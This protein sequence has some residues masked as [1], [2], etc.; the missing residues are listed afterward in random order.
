MSSREV[1]TDARA[2][3]DLTGKHSWDYSP[4]VGFRYVTVAD[5]WKHFIPL[6]VTFLFG[7]SGAPK[8]ELCPLGSPAQT[9]IRLWARRLVVTTRIEWLRVG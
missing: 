7:R 8:L 1:F 9:N 4:D 5:L 3:T 6:L 2:A